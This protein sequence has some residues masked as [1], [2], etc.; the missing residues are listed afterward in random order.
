LPR[1]AYRVTL[2]FAEIAYR[3]AGTRLFDVTLEGDRVLERYDPCTSGYAT[4]Q[5]KSFEITVEDGLL[6]IEFVSQK[7]YPKISAIAVQQLD[8]R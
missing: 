6:N 3:D 8:D 2:H 7:D 4:A 5:A 1:G